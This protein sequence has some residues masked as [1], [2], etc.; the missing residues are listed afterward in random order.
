MFR[1]E[2]QV[3]TANSLSG[4]KTQVLLMKGMYFVLPGNFLQEN[5]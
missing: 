2:I 4:I 1:K 3:L 5:V